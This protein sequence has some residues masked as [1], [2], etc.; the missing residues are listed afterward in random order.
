M[1]TISSGTRETSDMSFLLKFAEFLPML[2]LLPYSEERWRVHPVLPVLTVPQ[3]NAI[4][5]VRGHNL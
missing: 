5:M 4:A 3:G 2:W 1:N